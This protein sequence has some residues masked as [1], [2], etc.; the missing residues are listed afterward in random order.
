MLTAAD[1]RGREHAHPIGGIICPT[2]CPAEWEQL[3]RHHGLAALVP[4]ISMEADE[5]LPPR[6]PL[7]ELEILRVNDDKSARDLAVL[8]A[9]AY[10]MPVELF[11]CIS[12]KTFWSN[13]SYAF[14]GYINGQPVSC[15]AALH[16]MGTVYIA[17]VATSE[18]ARGKGYAETVMRKAISVG[19]KM[20]GT[21][22]TTLHASMMGQPLYE[23]MGYSSSV[24]LTLIGP[25]S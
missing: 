13:D 21:E 9:H 19:Q 15:A 10:H 11:D 12:K 18:D 20:M 8:N 6:R 2:W 16:V 25:E 23:A 3:I 22:R 5:L 1:A 17:L 14:V 7:A 24:H 4:M